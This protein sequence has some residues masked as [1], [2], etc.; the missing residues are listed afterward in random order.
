MIRKAYSKTGDSCR[1]T[2]QISA[3]EAA[4]Q[5]VT[6]LGEFNDWELRSHPL[7]RQKDGSFSLTL[8]LPI[9][10]D[11]R[12]RYLLDGERWQNDTGADDYRFNQF[13][14]QDSIVDL[15]A[16]PAAKTPKPAKAAKPAPQ[17]PAPAVAASPAKPA[18]APRAKAAPRT[19]P[20]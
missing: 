4:A 12:F 13:G 9:G 19:T 16:A 6:V 11:Y 5:S 18:K 7:D 20:R 1:V 17:A 3:E 8:A 15:S 14:S 2:F 10:R